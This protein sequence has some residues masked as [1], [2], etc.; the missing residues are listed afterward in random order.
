VSEAQ[1]AVKLY[2]PHYGYFE[3]RLKAVPIPGYMVALWMTGFEQHPEQSA[4][5]CIC[6]IFGREITAES[7]QIG[8]G[9]RPFG[10][11]ELTDEFYQDRI[12]I[13]AANYHIYA[14][15]WTPTNVSFLIDNVKTRT[16]F[17]TPDYPMQ[18]ML[19]FY[20]LPDQLTPEAKKTPWPK[21]FEVDYVRG[22]QRIAG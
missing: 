5:I 4:E 8:Y 22:Y 19:S 1:P 11:P 7:A 15:E 20:E 9:L 10:D 6:E 2:T 14:A 18:F 13:N 3:T 16:I 12:S 17:Q 21:T